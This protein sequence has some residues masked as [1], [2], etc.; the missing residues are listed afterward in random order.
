MDKLLK[1]IQSYSFSDKDMMKLVDNESN[2]VSYHEISKYKTLDK[3][4]GKYRACVILYLQTKNYGHWCCIF[5][6][7]DKPGL[8][9][10]YDPY[11]YF[12]DDEL[13]FNSDKK[14]IEL[15]Q[16]IPY[17]SMLMIN[18]SDKYD[19]VYNPYKL[20]TLSKGNNIC[21]RVVGL[22]LNFR[23]IDD[24]VFFDLLSKNKAYNKDEWVIMLTSFVN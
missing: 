14:N 5:E 19:Y 3:L 12:P 4:L 24:K 9:N 16:N 1:K 21:G 22:R 6:R 17:L 8:I 7:E 2:I 15:K 18:A 13:G 10:F 23:D 20:Q 11:G